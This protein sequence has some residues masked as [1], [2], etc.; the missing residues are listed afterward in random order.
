MVSGFANLRE[1]GVRI[2]PVRGKQRLASMES[3]VNFRAK[4]ARKRLMPL[5]FRQW[6]LYRFDF[7]VPVVGLEPTRSRPR[8]IL[9]PLRLPFHHTGIQ[10]DYYTLFCGQMQ[11]KF[12]SPETGMVQAVDP[13]KIPPGPGK[14]G[15]RGYLCISLRHAHL[16]Y[17]KPISQFSVRPGRMRVRNTKN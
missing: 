3:F 5:A 16:A 1:E 4:K 2:P 7:M 10:L 17:S 15:S 9:N 6:H 12:A 13:R 14:T 8:R 11:E